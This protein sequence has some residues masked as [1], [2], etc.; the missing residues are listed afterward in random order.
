MRRYPTD[1]PL[2]AICS[3][4]AFLALGFVDPGWGKGD[5]SFWHNTKTLIAGRWA[6]P[7]EGAATVGFL[8]LVLAVP[9]VVIGWLAHAVG[10]MC[11]VRLSR[12]RDAQLAADYDDAPPAP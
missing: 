1:K 6:S 4:A 3:L 9:A 11:G 10:V 7:M 12:Q 8:A 5:I 2:W